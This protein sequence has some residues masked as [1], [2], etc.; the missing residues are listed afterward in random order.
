MIDQ[1]TDDKI[2][3]YL[4]DNPKLIDETILSCWQQVAQDESRSAAI[5][6]IASNMAEYVKERIKEQYE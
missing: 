5:R 4:E 3:K 2:N 6:K 1:P